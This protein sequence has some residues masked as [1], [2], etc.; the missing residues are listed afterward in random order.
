MRPVIYVNGL[1][2]F[3]TASTYQTGFARFA[4]SESPDPDIHL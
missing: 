3:A 4:T 1:D 2:L